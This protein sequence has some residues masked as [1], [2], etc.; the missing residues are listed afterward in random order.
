MPAP[1]GAEKP[2]QPSLFDSLR[3]FWGVLV[4]I[5]YARLDLATLELEEAG[6]YAVKLILI[7]LAAL[8]CIALTIFFFLCFLV[9]L[10]GTH[11]LLVLGI[12][13]VTCLAVGAILVLA[14]RKMIAARPKFLGQTLAELRKDVE[15]IRPDLKTTESKS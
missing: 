10:S 9:V 1:E 12:I 15:K 7:S 14:A 11:L 5:V 3:V 6:T 4:A 8:F 13:C 2:A